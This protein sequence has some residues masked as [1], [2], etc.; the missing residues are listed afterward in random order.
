MADQEHGGNSAPKPITT[1]R[2]LIAALITNPPSGY[3]YQPGIVD[4]REVKEDSR[5]INLF[6]SSAMAARVDELMTLAIA[7]EDH[8]GEAS[9]E[10]YPWQFGDQ[11]RTTTQEVV[12]YHNIPVASRTT[13]APVGTPPDEIGISVVRRGIFRPSFSLKLYGRCERPSFSSIELTKYMGPE[14]Q[15]VDVYR[16]VDQLGGSIVCIGDPGW[17]NEAQKIMARALGLAK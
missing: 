11:Y 14:D 6:T 9:F 16:V 5:N 4:L 15:T 13:Y 10:G 8:L 1:V 12:T 2:E 17:N 3:G 7:G